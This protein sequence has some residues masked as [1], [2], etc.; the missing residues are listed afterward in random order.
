MLQ[1]HSTCLKQQLEQIKSINKLFF[2]R[3]SLK[4]SEISFFLDSKQKLFGWCCQNFIKRVW[5]ILW[6]ILF[7]I[8]NLQL[9][10]PDLAN[11]QGEKFANYGSDFLFVKYISNENQMVLFVFSL[12]AT[13]N[14]A[15]RF[16]LL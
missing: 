12:F 13:E 1:L 11:H 8:K 5:A 2:N 4:F 6:T 3:N 7:F 14:W 16:V 15:F 10:Q 9:M